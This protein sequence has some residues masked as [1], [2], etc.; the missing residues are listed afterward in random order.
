[1]RQGRFLVDIG[2][3]LTA[4]DA[5]AERAAERVRRGATAAATVTDLAIACVVAAVG[6]AKERRATVKVG[7]GK[8]LM[9]LPVR[10]RRGVVV[11]IVEEATKRHDL[12][13]AEIGGHGK[14][15]VLAEAASVCRGKSRDEIAPEIRALN[16]LED[17]ANVICE[18]SSVVL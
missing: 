12:R 5:L 6:F 14:H 18:G 13:E 1:V 10:E 3:V 2:E 15:E 4:K 11:L 7:G 8:G 17:F 16:A 9:G